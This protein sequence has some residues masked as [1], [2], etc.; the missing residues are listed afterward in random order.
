M[1]GSLVLGMQ[2]WGRR[3]VAER[4]KIRDWRE[5]FRLLEES[6]A[7]ELTGQVRQ[8]GRVCTPCSKQSPSWYSGK[9]KKDLELLG[10]SLQ[11]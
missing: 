3:Q 2:S 10:E 4:L 8:V 1:G 9:A 7:P 6:K 5:V 11:H